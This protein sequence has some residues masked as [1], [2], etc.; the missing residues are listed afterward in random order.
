VGERVAKEMGG[1]KKYLKR[2]RGGS[3]PI[4]EG[5]EDRKIKDKKIR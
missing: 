5:K 3:G 2:E 4:H 1:A